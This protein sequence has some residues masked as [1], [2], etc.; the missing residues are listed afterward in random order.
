V[1]SLH[2]KCLHPPKNISTA[3]PRLERLT[4]LNLESTSG[5]EPDVLAAV[6]Q[7]KKLQQLPVTC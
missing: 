4:A 1:Q 6:V 7:L 2:I 5:F 3:L